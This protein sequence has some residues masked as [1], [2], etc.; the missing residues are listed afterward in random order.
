MDELHSCQVITEDLSVP[1][2]WNDLE[3]C[4]RGLCQ[5]DAAGKRRRIG[6]CGVMDDNCVLRC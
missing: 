2:D 6:E 3:L 5:R 1:E 4:Y